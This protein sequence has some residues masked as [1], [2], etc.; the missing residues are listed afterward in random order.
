MRPSKE[1]DALNPTFL[2][3]NAADLALT[4]T[5]RAPSDNRLEITGERSWAMQVAHAWK[6]QPKFVQAVEQCQRD[7]RSEAILQAATAPAGDLKPSRVQF[8]HLDGAAPQILAIWDMRP[9]ALAPAALDPV[10][11]LPDRR[12]LSVAWAKLTKGDVASHAAVLFFDIDNFKAVNDCFGHAAG[13]Y[14]LRVAAERWRLEIRTDDELVRYGG[15]EFVA[16]LAGV[17]NDEA[18]LHISSRLRQTTEQ[19]IEWHGRRILI[20]VS[21]GAVRAAAGSTIEQLIEQA[22]HLMYQ[23]K[24]RTEQPPGGGRAA[25]NEAGA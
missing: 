15:D 3:F 14:V 18:L 23:A 5:S 13:D 22:D 11:G 16:L 12:A 20:R 8:V 6:S 7:G 2:L 24:R 17:E 4:A 9:A 19:P 1:T 10:T 21:M 25:R